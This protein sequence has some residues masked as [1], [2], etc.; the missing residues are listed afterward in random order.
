MGDL[1]L[2]PGLGRS[3]GEGKGDPLHY[4][5]L[6]NSMD[7]IVHEVTKS[8]TRL[9]DFHSFSYGEAKQIFS[10]KKLL[11]FQECAVLSHNI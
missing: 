8:Q 9:S 11:G 2:I 1:G 4:V 6:E 10:L 7:C 5:S 3:L